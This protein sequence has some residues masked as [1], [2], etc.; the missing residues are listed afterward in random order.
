MSGTNDLIELDDGAAAKQTTT[1]DSDDGH[2]GEVEDD[3]SLVRRAFDQFSDSNM[4][5]EE[6]EVPIEQDR[7]SSGKRTAYNNRKTGLPPPKPK[8]AL[9][10]RVSFN[11]DHPEVHHLTDEEERAIHHGSGRLSLVSKMY[12]VDG[13]G[14]LGMLYVHPPMIVKDI[15]AYHVCILIAKHYLIHTLTTYTLSI[16]PYNIS[17]YHINRR[18]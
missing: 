3:S 14:K 11:E 7:Q 12:D 9:K 4:D 15:C 5:M 18:G 16:P 13:D 1:S 2:I 8:S 10:S 6:G 17:H